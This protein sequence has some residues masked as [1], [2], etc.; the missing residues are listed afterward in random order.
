M[1]VGALDVERTKE[2]FRDLL[3]IFDKL[4]LPTHA[5]CHVQYILFY[6][7]SFRVVSVRSTLFLNG[8]D[9]EEEWTRGD[10]PCEMAAASF[11][12]LKVASSIPRSS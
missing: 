10:G 6:L 5:S 7:C 8:W 12:N 4:I 9:L 1:S 3:S 11:C 2:L